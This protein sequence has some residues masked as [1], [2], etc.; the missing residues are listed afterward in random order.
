MFEGVPAVTVAALMPTH[1]YWS[2]FPL[3]EFLNEKRRYLFENAPGPVVNTVPPELTDR[4]IFPKVACP[5][6][7]ALT[8]LA[9]EFVRKATF[10]PPYP[11]VTSDR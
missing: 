9:P 5:V 6:L 8:Q 1:P 10:M 7:E 3:E 4:M 11:G 2:W